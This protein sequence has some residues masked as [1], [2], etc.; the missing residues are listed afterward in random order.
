M[1]FLSPL[2]PPGEVTSEF[3]PEKQL[4]LRHGSSLALINDVSR[5]LNESKDFTTKDPTEDWMSWKIRSDSFSLYFAALFDMDGQPVAVLRAV[6]DGLPVPIPP[7]NKRLLIDYTYVIPTMRNKGLATILCEFVVNMCTMVGANSYV[8]ALE[9]S[10]VYWMS[11]GFLLEENK[12][13]QARLNIFPDTHLLRQ[14]GDPLDVGNEA[15]MAM[16]VIHDTA[17][18]NDSTGS[19]AGSQSSQQAEEEEATSSVVITG[20]AGDDEEEDIARAIA[21]SLAN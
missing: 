4:F 2:P 13:L 7:H 9:D 6:L 8:L 14:L 21:A 1:D 16:Q 19:N 20:G 5:L 17:S 11:K 12:F 15:D 18:D 10:C 3:L